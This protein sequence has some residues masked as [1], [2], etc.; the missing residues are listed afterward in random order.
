VA[1]GQNTVKDQTAV[2]IVPGATAAVNEGAKS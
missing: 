1:V 2:E